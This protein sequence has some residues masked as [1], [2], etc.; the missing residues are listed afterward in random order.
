MA[1]DLTTNLIQGAYLLFVHNGEVIAYVLGALIALV[2]LIAR[3][4]RL[5]VL[6]FLAFGLLAFN[7]EYDKHIMLPLRAQTI[8]TITSNPD[9]HLYT[10]RLINLFLTDLLPVAFF[11]FGWGLLFLAIIL[12]LLNTEAKTAKLKKE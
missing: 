9:T 6:Y 3:P 12:S 5:A 2:A 1:S 10:Q 4:T 8:A 7:F 11:A